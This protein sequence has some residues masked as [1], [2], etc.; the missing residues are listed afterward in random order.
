MGLKSDMPLKSDAELG[1]NSWLQDEL[2]Q[3]YLR[4]RATV[5]DSWKHLFETA[6]APESSVAGAAEGLEVALGGRSRGAVSLCRTR[7]IENPLPG[8]IDRRVVVQ[9]L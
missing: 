3:Q 1:V 9:I 7:L 5:D 4:D 2:Y 6:G 8:F